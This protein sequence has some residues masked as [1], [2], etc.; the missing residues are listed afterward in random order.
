MIRFTLRVQGGDRLTKRPAAGS[1]AVASLALLAVATRGESLA[2]ASAGSPLVYFGTYTGAGSQGIYVS[3]LDVATGGLTPPELAA[4]TP[5]PSFLVADSSGRHLYAVN[6][7]D[8]FQGAKA[9]FA[10]AFAVERPTGMLSAL[11]QVST[12]GSGP[13]HIS[14]DKAGRHAFVANYGGGSATVLPIRDDGSLAPASAFVQHE[15]HGPDAQRQ[16]GPH[17]HEAL[18]D[19]EQRLLWVADLGLDAV[20]AYRFDATKGTLSTPAAERAIL[21][22]SSGPRHFAFSADGRELFVLSEMALTVTSFRLSGATATVDQ[23]LSTLPEGVT[24]SA[25]FSAA[26]I[27]VHP[28]GRFLYASNRG[29]DSI[30]VF[31]IDRAKGGLRRLEVVPT[32]GKTPRGFA[33]DPTGGYLVVGN[34]DSNEIVVFAIDQGTGR[35][36]RVGHP[37]RVVSPVSVA[38]V[39]DAAPERR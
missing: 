28:S 1:F 31:S 14:L 29:P 11:D 33:I 23:T 5:N 39:P 19:P 38:F 26:E 2:S 3:R 37:V 16:E 30:A 20:L 35:L 10:T 4:S 13:C 27:A 6:E 15:G 18:L 34:Q 21:A 36:A 17:A 32:G 8:E 12:G 7:L 22:P 25:A 9:G 24:P